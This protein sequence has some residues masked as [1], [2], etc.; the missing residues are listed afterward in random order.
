MADSHDDPARDPKLGFD[1][2]ANSPDRSCHHAA[3]FEA[4]AMAGVDAL[5]QIHH[6]ITCA[7][8]FVTAV[9]QVR[10]AVDPISSNELNALLN[11]LDTEFKRRLRVAKAAVAAVPRPPTAHKAG[12]M[13]APT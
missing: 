8:K 12:E 7:R 6:A 4:R 5:K 11:V 10:D 2:A 13:R 3:E 1:A 9:H